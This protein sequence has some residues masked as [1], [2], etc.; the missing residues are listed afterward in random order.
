MRSFFV[1]LTLKTSLTLQVAD[2][3]I[4]TNQVDREATQAYRKWTRSN[5]HTI[6]VKKLVEKEK[7]RQ[8]AR[9]LSSRYMAQN[10]ARLLE[11]LK[12]PGKRE[13][14]QFIHTFMSNMAANGFDRSQIVRLYTEYMRRLESQKR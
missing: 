4:A 14:Y 2:I 1:F 8:E 6:F 11:T 5:P 12:N 7:A 3:V 9:A 10:K 13:N